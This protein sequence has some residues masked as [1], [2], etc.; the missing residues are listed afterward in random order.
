M[1]LDV[2]SELLA[3]EVA[4]LAADVISPFLF[5]VQLLGLGRELP[6]KKFA[7]ACRLY[8]AWYRESDRVRERHRLLG[9]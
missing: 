6:K 7:G 3:N 8:I 9:R 4:L 5:V 2:K 1:M